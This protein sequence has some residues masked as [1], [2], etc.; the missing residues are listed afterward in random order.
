MKKIA[1]LALAVKIFFKFLLISRP[2][3]SSSGQRGGAN[4]TTFDAVVTEMP[5]W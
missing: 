3:R 5:K 2:I 4:H 1:V